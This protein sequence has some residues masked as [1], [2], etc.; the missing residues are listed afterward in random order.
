MEP[1]IRYNTAMTVKIKSHIAVLGCGAWATTIANHI[2]KKNIPTR[3]WCHREEIVTEINQKKERSLL[4]G[5]DLSEHLEASLDCKYVLDN[6]T[7]IIL[8]I[9]SKY[10]EA[11]IPL[12]KP[13][14]NHEQPVLSLIK[15]ILSEQYM[16]IEDYLKDIF[17]KIN[18]SIV[19]GPNLALEIAQE[20]PAASVVASLDRSTQ[21]FF[22]EL[23]SNH[24]L[25]VYRSSDM[26]GVASGG[27]LKNIMAI[28]GGIVDGL[29]LGVNS[30]SSLITRAL[31]EMIAFGTSWGAFPDTLYGLSGLGDLMA[32]SFSPLSRNYQCG[33][34]L[35]QGQTSAQFEEKLNAVAEGIKSTTFIYNYSRE[36]DIDMPITEM[37]YNVINTSLSI[38]DAINQ[39]MTRDLKSE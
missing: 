13:Y 32:T 17:P 6:A 20:K 16:F 18:Y 28:A 2:A 26:K 21:V 36:H 22:Q 9:P 3:I 19:S 30:K 39:L 31:K 33:F 27:L 12:W 35:A 38:N 1:K 34:A 24:Y 37:V 23:L 25:R 4:P 7:A 29:E 10:L 15:G 14:F 5:I 8:C 11:F